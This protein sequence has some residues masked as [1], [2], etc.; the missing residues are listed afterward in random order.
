[1]VF[2][3][4]F[5]YISGFSTRD[6]NFR[7]FYGTKEKDVKTTHILS[8]GL[9]S[10]ESSLAQ[11]SILDDFIGE[12]YGVTVALTINHLALTIDYGP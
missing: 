2:S 9:E 3:S 6:V 5:F 11:T 1:M 8:T 4:F 10:I 7:R 12:R